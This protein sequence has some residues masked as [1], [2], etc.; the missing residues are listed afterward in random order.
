MDAFENTLKVAFAEAPEPVD[1]GFAV[2]VAKR[3]SV[4]ERLTVLRNGVQTFGI[5][6]AAVAATYGGVQLVQNVAPEF[7]AS[8]GL[9]FARAHGAI[10]QANMNTVLTAALLACAAVGG[11]AL[12]LR[13]AQG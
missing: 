9:E 4:R 1:D 12:A 8:A 2:G 11:G 3:V 7:L 6:I 5:A 10:A 13:S